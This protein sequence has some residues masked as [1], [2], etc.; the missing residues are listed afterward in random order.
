MGTG[1]EKLETT[2]QEIV[3]HHHGEC[4]LDPG[5][6]DEEPMSG[7]RASRVSRHLQGCQGRVRTVLQKSEWRNWME[8]GIGKD[9]RPASCPP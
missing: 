5:A 8:G 2:S 4:C 9:I 1:G 3:S 6:G 7:A